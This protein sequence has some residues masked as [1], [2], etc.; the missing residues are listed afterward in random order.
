MEWNFLIFLLQMIGMV[1]VICFVYVILRKR[2]RGGAVIEKGIG[3]TEGHELQELRRMRNH[4]LNVPLSELTRPAQLNDIIGQ[5][6]GIKALRAALCGPN[7]QHVIIYGPPGVGKTC[8]AR[9]VLEE[10]KKSV[11]SPFSTYSKFVE[12]DAT[13]VR[14]D[15]RAIA[16]PLMGSVHDP[17]YQGAGALGSQGVPQPKPGAVSRAHCGVL[18]LDEIGEL[19]PMQMNKLLKVLEDRK[20]SFE[21][22]YY[23]KDN[24]SIP[25]YIHDIFQNGLPADFRLVGA[26]T[27]QPEELPPA[28]RSR[29][30]ELY[31][32]PL[33]QPELA[34]IAAGAAERIGYGIR[35]GALRLCAMYAASGRDAVNIIQLASGAAYSER[36]H[37]IQ[38][39]DIRWVARTCNYALRQPFHIRESP[40]AG[41]CAGLAVTGV[42]QGA[43]I[44][45]ECVATPAAKGNGK[46]V[47][48][49]VVEEEELELR[50]RRLRR[51]STARSSIENVIGALKKR[52]D[53]DCSDYDIHINIPGGVPMDGP[54]AG[55]ALAVA[56]VSAV[57]GK[58]P[59][60]KIALTG[61]IS[62]H[63][64]ILPVGGV[65]EKVNAA[66]EAGAQLIVI[67]SENYEEAY[68]A[69]HARIEPV[70]DIQQVIRLAFDL[71]RHHITEK[72]EVLGAAPT[73]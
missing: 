45:I 28:L 27:R 19:H 35:P 32:M 33:G 71:Q 18:F 66:I 8:A 64:D 14:F 25:A 72:T 10:A 44:E 56:V 47:I 21:S 63:G 60:Q 40:D 59:V 6:E 69:M 13:C 11:D 41:I 57:T 22:A 37:E 62:I 4:S 55:A 70:T 2:D 54:S 1:A 65:R 42:G 34:R 16:D 67:P 26:T 52:L 24:R 23:S 29:C 49:G 61:E 3:K 68:A 38:E 48:S 9:L 73:N 30:M 36:R 39:P 53:I 15:E 51:K 31:F 20:V 58:A 43:V 17:I 12:I 7:P 50:G 46:L 5:E